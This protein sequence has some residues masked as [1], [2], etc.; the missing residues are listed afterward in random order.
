MAHKNESLSYD[1]LNEKVQK[2]LNEYTPEKEEVALDDTTRIKVLSPGQLVFK[3]FIRS[4]L[5]VIGMAVL[6]FMF[7]L[8]F[9]GPLFSPYGEA[10]LFYR[11]E[12]VY[13]KQ[14]TIIVNDETNNNADFNIYAFNSTSEPD[15]ILS[16]KMKSASKRLYLSY[17]A[18]STKTS[19]SFTYSDSEY[20]LEVLGDNLVRINKTGDNYYDLYTYSNLI[21]RTE[22]SPKI[23]PLV[24]V[25]PI[26]QV[27]V[28]ILLY[29][30]IFLPTSTPYLN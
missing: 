10:E 16:G 20:L 23:R 6:L 5:S 17:L 4:K 27:K 12:S 9:L 28:K 7:L 18:D 29:P 8:C 24:I 2:T 11:Y 19:A 14:A 25:F 3:R 13:S 1:S 15:A 26:R 30:Q 22:S 21:K